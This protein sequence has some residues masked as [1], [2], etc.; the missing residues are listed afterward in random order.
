MGPRPNRA[1]LTPNRLEFPAEK[2]GINKGHVA[3]IVF[4]LFF[5]GF[6]VC[7]LWNLL[8]R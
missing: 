5:I 1:G 8:S 4:G 7:C 2:T 3:T 6:G